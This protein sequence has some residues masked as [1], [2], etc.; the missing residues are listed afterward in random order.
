MKVGLSMKLISSYSTKFPLYSTST[1]IIKNYRPE[2]NQSQALSLNARLIVF[3]LRAIINDLEGKLQK[4]P[5]TI[6]LLE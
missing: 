4:H 1:R 6:Y 5:L 3:K 2:L